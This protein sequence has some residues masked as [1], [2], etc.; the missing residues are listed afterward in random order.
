MSERFISKDKKEIWCSHPVSPST[1]RTL[2]GSIL[3]Q[4]PSLSH[5]VR[6]VCY[7][8]FSSFI[9]IYVPKFVAFKW[10]NAKE[11]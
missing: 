8:T 7:S 4:E 1:R 5:F 11:R 10:T 6:R 9:K 2:S 3:W